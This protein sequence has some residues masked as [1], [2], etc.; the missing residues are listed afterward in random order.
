MGPW[1]WP[2]HHSCLFHVIEKL[3]Y[4]AS[5]LRNLLSRHTIYYLNVSPM[6]GDGPRNF[7]HPARSNET[8]LFSLGTRSDR[9]SPVLRA[10][11]ARI[12]WLGIVYSAMPFIDRCCGWIWTDG[13]LKL[14]ADRLVVFSF[15]VPILDWRLGMSGGISNTDV[16]SCDMVARFR[17]PTREH[18]KGK[19][20]L[21]IQ[22]FWPTRI[23]L[24]FI[25]LST[26]NAT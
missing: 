8:H 16:I 3:V 10:D 12:A 2:A 17:F 24:P 4:P 20:H 14:E 9:F 1:R 13:N 15:S 23:L 11:L 19:L 25:S 22:N 7:S 5:P 26:G 6:I 18:I 21:A